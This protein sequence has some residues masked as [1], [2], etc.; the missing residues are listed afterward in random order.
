MESQLKQTA[1]V[2]FYNQEKGYGFLKMDDA[3][4]VFCHATNIDGKIGLGERVEFDI[5]KTPRGLKAINVKTI[6]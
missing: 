5:E 2:K 1:Q 3:T 4:E 6:K